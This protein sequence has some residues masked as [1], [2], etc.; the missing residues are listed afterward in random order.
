MPYATT[1]APR[2]RVAVL[3]RCF[4]VLDGEVP[5]S[6]G[7]G[8]EASALRTQ[9]SGANTASQRRPSALLVLSRPP[10]GA[11][12]PACASSRRSVRAASSSSGG[13]RRPAQRSLAMRPTRRRRGFGKPPSNPL[14]LRLAAALMLRSTPGDSGLNLPHCWCESPGRSAALIL[15]PT[16]G[17]F[18][19]LR[20]C[21]GVPLYS[22][23]QP[24]TAM[25]HA[26]LL[27]SRKAALMHERVQTEAPIPYNRE[28]ILQGGCLK[29][30]AA[31]GRARRP[32]CSM[33]FPDAALRARGPT[34]HLGWPGFIV[35]ANL[36]LPPHPHMWGKE[37]AGARA[38]F[39]LPQSSL[40]LP[41]CALE[42][43]L[44]GDVSPHTPA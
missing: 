10:P 25:R 11:P 29:W 15:P 4:T 1:M 9:T 30:Q 8:Q 5:S 42:V 39:A 3:L 12:S 14:T 36:L 31:R 17:K 34:M 2:T 26:T 28:A 22:P 33:R 20:L 6:R 40:P 43:A 7:T 13:C 41:L 23:A 32:S 37:L 19:H 27:D 35:H 16:G 18:Y 44:R 38:R 21:M 24:C